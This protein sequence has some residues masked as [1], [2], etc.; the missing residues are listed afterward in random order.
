MEEEGSGGVRQWR[1]R[2]VE[3]E[4]SGGGGKEI[5][6]L[7]VFRNCQMCTSSSRSFKRECAILFR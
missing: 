7:C 4:G 1:R 2:E 6:L 3:E 5:K